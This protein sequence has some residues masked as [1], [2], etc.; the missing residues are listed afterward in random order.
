MT[1]DDDA[2]DPW[3]LRSPETDPLPTSIVEPTVDLRT[4]EGHTAHG[5]TLP[6]SP[7]EFP[8]ETSLESLQAELLRLTERVDALERSTG[9]RTRSVAYTEPSQAPSDHQ[10]ARRRTRSV[11]QAGWQPAK[12]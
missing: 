11:R 5:I 10:P 12:R 8:T 3:D 1:V 4:P 7:R 6:T 2:I 9:T